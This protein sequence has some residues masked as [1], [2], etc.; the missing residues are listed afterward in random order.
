VSADLNRRVA[1]AQAAALAITATA[2]RAAP[3]RSLADIEHRHGGRLGVFV[4]DSASP[5][6]LAWRADERFLM[7]STFKTLA[8]AQVLARVDA[9]RESLQRRVPYSRADLLEYAPITRAHVGEGALSVEALCRA[10]IEVSDNTA[11]NL[12][13]ASIGGPVG[14]TVFAR[15]LGDLIT[16]QDRREPDANRADGDKDTTSPR[17]MAASVR[18]ILLGDVLTPASRARLEGWMIAATVGLNR[19]RAGVPANWR[20]GDKGGTGDT[21]TNDV[22]ILRPPG[23]APLIVTAYYASSAGDLPARETVLR[24]VGTLVANWVASERQPRSRG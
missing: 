9:G 13:L 10:A 15:S 21:E 7:C 1:I 17:A 24:E 16:R 19:I 11:A 12:L 2:A 3:A 23:R 14:V 8:V 20:A 18:A 22:A 5:R 4:L 6:S